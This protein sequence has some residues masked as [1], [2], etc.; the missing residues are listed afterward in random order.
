VQYQPYLDAA[1]KPVTKKVK[2][3]MSVEINDAK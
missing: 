2:L 3:R 1:G